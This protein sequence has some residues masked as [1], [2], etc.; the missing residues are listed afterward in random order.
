MGVFNKAIPDI[1][2]NDK[3]EPIAEYQQPVYI[4]DMFD[5]LFNKNVRN[6]LKDKYKY[7]I[8]RTLAGFAEGLDNALVPSRSQG[9]WGIMGP[10]MG[11]LSNFGRTMDKAGDFLI[12]GVTEGINATSKLLGNDVEVNNPLKEIFVNDED[13]SGQRLLASMTNSMSKLAGGTKVDESAFRGMWAIPSTAL[14]LALDP[15]VLGGSVARRLAPASRNLTSREILHNIGNKIGN[16]NFKGAVGDVAQLLSNYDDIM[17]KIAFDYTAPGLRPAVKKFAH[18]INSTLGNYSTKPF[19]DVVKE[20]AENNP[21]I[22]NFDISKINIDNM[23][24]PSVPPTINQTDNTVVNNIKEN[25]TPSVLDNTTKELNEFNNR[26]TF[27]YIEM[28]DVMLKEIED[29]YKQHKNFKLESPEDLELFYFIHNL[30]NN[31]K[32]LKLSDEHINSIAEQ[33]AKLINQNKK[34]KEL[35]DIQKNS[36]TKEQYKV[37]SNFEKKY[38]KRLYTSSTNP[39]TTIREFINTKENADAFN[40]LIEQLENDKDT[41]L[42]PGYTYDF[43]KYYRDFDLEEEAIGNRAASN[44]VDTITKKYNL[45]LDNRDNR[46][47]WDLYREIRDGKYG[48]E[49]SD[50]FDDLFD[51]DYDTFNENPLNDY[52]IDITR[53]AD[54]LDKGVFATPNS[55]NTDREMG[56]LRNLVYGLMRSNAEK[57][58]PSITILDS[59]FIKRN[60]TPA[61]V[62]YISNELYQF[63]L[64]NFYDEIPNLDFSRPVINTGDVLNKLK[65]NILEAYSVDVSKMDTKA[66]N[67]SLNEIDKHLSYNLNT[68]KD[69]LDPRD[70]DKFFS[71]LNKNK[72]AKKEYKKKY[73]YNSDDYLN[74]FSKYYEDINKLIQ[75]AD[76]LERTSYKNIPAVVDF[77]NTTRKIENTIAYQKGVLEDEHFKA[78]ESLLY[79]SAIDDSEKLENTVLEGKSKNYFS[80]K[81]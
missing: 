68:I 17:T 12:G 42:G 7:P 15:G 30:R 29:S 27:P 73:D 47:I 38:A 45:K 80:D 44:A 11:I 14:E 57:A 19:I 76:Y 60:N 4:D 31:I 32:P 58:S 54:D 59:S 34:L 9:Q 18:H 53:L 78:N 52:Y 2:L 40:D 24:T 51:K 10:S 66:I 36:L 33:Y 13:Y 39:Y 1:N 75:T 21:D 63:V 71:D 22:T 50:I 26:R 65:R 28:Y 3:D 62:N 23:D 37:I 55:L 67:E 61:V 72:N 77:I 64:R 70:K 74:T 35:A 49:L 25:S 56:N 41:N 16:D 8:Y 46:D 6:Y 81:D 69:I 5:P 43:R 48:D 20:Y 79:G